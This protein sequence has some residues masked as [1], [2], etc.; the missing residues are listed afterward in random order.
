MPDREYRSHDKR[1]GVSMPEAELE[2]MLGFCKKANGKETGGVVVGSY[3]A[4]HDCA[5]V[6]TVSKAP[7]DSKAGHT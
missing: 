1:F 2:R 3:S 4:G 7:K 6:K 5:L